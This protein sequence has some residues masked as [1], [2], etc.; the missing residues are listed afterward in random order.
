MV[1]DMIKSFSDYVL[2]Y[3]VGEI[4]CSRFKLWKYKGNE[5]S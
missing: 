5:F 3:V 2:E 1:L 4:D